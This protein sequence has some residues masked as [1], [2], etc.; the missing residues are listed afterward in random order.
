MS[1]VIRWYRQL[2]WLMATHRRKPREKYVFSA[3]YNRVGIDWDQLVRSQTAKARSQGWGR[4][5]TPTF[6]RSNMVFD[7][8]F[9]NAK[10]NFYCPVWFT[11]EQKIEDKCS[12]HG[13][14]HYAAMRI[15]RWLKLCFETRLKAHIAP[16]PFNFNRTAS[17]HPGGLFLQPGGK[18]RAREEVCPPPLIFIIGRVC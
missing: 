1:I 12:W 11:K 14:L 4:L 6:G 8:Y 5:M 15:V 13:D 16:K 3:M 2:H 7:R 17:R 18:E 10:L 9:F